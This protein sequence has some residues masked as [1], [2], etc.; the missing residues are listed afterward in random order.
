M[1]AFF[2]LLGA[3]EISAPACPS[4]EDIAARWA[5]LGAET[6]AGEAHISVDEDRLRVV[7]L[8]RDGG[9]RADRELRVPPSCSE[10]AA[11]A[12]V[13]LAAWATPASPPPPP[14]PTVITRPPPPATIRRTLS[15]EIAASF[16]GAVA[17]AGFAASAGLDLSL[18]HSRSGWGGHLSLIGGDTRRVDLGTVSYANYARFPL[19]LG[20]RR[21]FV[22]SRLHID[23]SADASFALVYVRGQSFT[24]N[25]TRYSFD[26]GLGTGVRLGW[27]IGAW[28]PFIGAAVVGW[29]TRQE[30][31]VANSSTSSGRL[32]RIDGL[33]S[34]GISFEP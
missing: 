31:A 17:G 30:L 6:L 22:T 11:I 14:A 23:L 4:A 24:I 21:R 26:F 34:A 2:V 27:G 18:I 8:D 28:T 9:V 33:L 15:T 10:R 16:V 19:S 1:G 20:A 7:L 13:V 29:L 32:P 3:L 5:A 12:A 25:Q